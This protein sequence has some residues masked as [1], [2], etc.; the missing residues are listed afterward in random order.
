M[1]FIN[2]VVIITGA[3]SGIGKAS[4]IKF[5]KLSATLSLIDINEDNL[6]KVTEECRNLSE[7]KVLEVV[8]DISKDVDVKRSVENTIEE[9]GRIDVLVN[10]AGIFGDKGILDSDLLS[11][12]DKVMSVNLRA[13]IA[14]IHYAAPALIESKGCVINTA[15]VM[16]KL[17][18]KGA[19]PYNLSKAAVVYFT[20]HVAMD[21]AD[22][23]V[24]VNSISP[25]PVETNIAL[26]AGISQEV[27]DAVF[28]SYAKFVP[29]QH[30]IEAT[31][32]AEMAV[33][34]ASD[35]ARSITGSDFVID[36]GLALSGLASGNMLL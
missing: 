23:G 26:H 20:K 8:A 3:G 13:T 31:E 11:V 29:L 9:F 36:S 6:N 24:R 4:A 35:K 19:I 28:A 14:M 27:N 17:V 10:C 1:S 7:A 16:A 25:G 2:K 30:N 34:L 21:L 33:Y 32:V 5:A 12:I 22:K 15:S 18:C